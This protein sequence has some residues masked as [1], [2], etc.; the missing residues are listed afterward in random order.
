M[1]TY[2]D[3]QP[4]PETLRWSSSTVVNAPIRLTRY[5]QKIRDGKKEILGLHPMGYLALRSEL[6]A[7]FTVLCDTRLRVKGADN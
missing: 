6:I 5:E 3:R 7:T 4:D 1:P 2:H